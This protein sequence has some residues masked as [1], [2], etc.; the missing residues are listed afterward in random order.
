MSMK[1][2][3]IVFQ[4]WSGVLQ[5]ETRDLDSLEQLRNRALSD[6][7]I[8][9]DPALKGMIRELVEKRRAELLQR[10]HEAQSSAAPSGSQPSWRS[11][12]PEPVH[13]TTPEQ[14]LAAFSQLAQALCVSLEGGDE[15]ETRGILGR[16][17]TIQERRPD[18]I[19]QDVI[20]QYEQRVDALRTHLR[21]LADETSL[22]AKQVV[23]ASRKGKI[24]DLVQAMRR[25]TAIHVAHP[26]LLDESGLEELRKNVTE[27]ADERRQHER[28]TNKLLERER[29]I[30]AEIKTLAAAVRHFHQVACT[31]PYPSKEFSQ[32]EAAYLRAIQRAETYDTE[33]FSGVVL[34]LADLL[35]EWS[36][37]PP[38][39]EGQID[40]FLDS[41]SAGLDSIRTE[42]REI[43]HDSD[44][45][46]GNPP[47]ASG[48]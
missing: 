45:R 38:R 14:D 11:D 40:R 27:A 9:H 13:T 47:A 3:D 2:R 20:G 31:L 30:T 37:P 48:P 41:I 5:R 4:R 26:R 39:A 32:A 28:T 18:L 25:L 36:V 34:Q 23:T 21:Q 29:S 24:E 19:P 1:Q 44:Q 46:K 35:A 16:M 42:M 8:R 15:N 12:P 17:Q 6:P 43:E 33:W 22:L 10:A 7:D